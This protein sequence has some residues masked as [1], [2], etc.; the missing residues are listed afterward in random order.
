MSMSL[1][2]STTEA[3]IKSSQREDDD[4]DEEADEDDYHD[5]DCEQSESNKAANSS[6]VATAA[7]VANN[8][9]KQHPG[10]SKTSSNKRFPG[11]HRGITQKGAS[12]SKATT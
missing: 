10:K 12:S 11:I 3:N 2:T 1:A 7:A 6:L 4:E 8:R 5:E 9:P